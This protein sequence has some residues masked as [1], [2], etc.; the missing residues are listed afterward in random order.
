[1]NKKKWK[2]NPTYPEPKWVRDSSDPNLEF[3]E[4]LAYKIKMSGTP[5]EHLDSDELFVCT[6]CKESKDFFIEK[7]NHHLFKCG[8]CSSLIETGGS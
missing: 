5:A 6:H 8:K 2:S 1:M 3:N 7:K 4:A